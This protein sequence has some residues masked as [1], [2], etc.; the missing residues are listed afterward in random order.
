MQNLEMLKKLKF[1]LFLLRDKIKYGRM[2]RRQTFEYIYSKK[3]WDKSGGKAEFYSGPGSHEDKYVD[4]YCEL[5]RRFISE[6]NITEVCDIGCGDFNVASK[7]LNDSVQYMGIDIVQKMIDHHNR[8][9]ANDHISFQCMD[10]VEQPLPD[11]Q[12]CLVRQVLQHLNNDEVMQVLK[13]IKKYKYVIITE[14]VTEKQYAKEYNTDKA[15]GSG[16]R[17]YNQSGLYFDEAPFNL[18]VQTLLEIPCAGE[19]KHEVLISVLLQK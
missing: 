13:K 3:K 14:S 18:K 7:W 19:R 9:Y 8:E 12:L 4:P 1:K 17:V 11:A 15:H 5:I 2:D 16:I 6:H 10:I